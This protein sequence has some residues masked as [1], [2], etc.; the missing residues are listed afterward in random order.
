M[1]V[2]NLSSINTPSFIN[3]KMFNG[4]SYYSYGVNNLY[5]QELLDITDKSETH[6]ACLEYKNLAIAGQGYTNVSEGADE[7]LKKLNYRSEF[8]TLLNKI[9]LSTA[10]FDGFGLQ[11]IW[12][13]ARTA[14]VDVKYTPFENIRV[15]KCDDWGNPE[16]FFINNDWL[17]YPTNFTCLKT[18]NADPKA[19]KLSGDLP[20]LLYVINKSPKSICYPNP[21]YAAAINAIFAEYEMGVH[22]LSSITNG[23]SLSKI[24][25]FIVSGEPT[26]EKQQENKRK[27][28]NAFRGTENAGKIIVEYAESPDNKV[29]VQDLTPSTIVDQYI[30]ASQSAQTKI[31][32]AHGI[33]S[34]A[35]LGL[36][37]GNSS[38]FSNGE[39]LLAAYDVF[40]TNKIKPYHKM[41]EEA[42]NLILEFAGFPNE[43]YK[44]LPFSPVSV[45]Q[46]TTDSTETVKTPTD[47]T[48][49]VTEEPTAEADTNQPTV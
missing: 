40:F 33:T 16:E 31:L 19:I 47:T 25:T 37:D 24:F 13:K 11:I 10:I 7:F 4:K 23:F 46:T 5:P 43:D 8:T 44:I 26:V 41:I 35:L 38:I 28:D 45:A 18:F 12:N 9:A 21:R 49:D 15:G 34:P 42:F 2:Y 3:E 48:T 27:F 32:L 36:G 29:I 39:E 6:S 17:Q 1:E 30:N 14:I 22:Q 20:Q